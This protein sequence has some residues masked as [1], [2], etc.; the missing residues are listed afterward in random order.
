LEWEPAI[1]TERRKMRFLVIVEGVPGVPL[2]PPEQSLALTKAQ[3]EWAKGTKDSG[4]ADVVYALADHDGGLTGGFGIANVQSLEE[5][6][7][8]L[9]SMPMAGLGTS[10]VYP[11]VDLNSALKIVD[12]KLEALPK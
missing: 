2:L 3:W 7:E 5:L 11:L 4:K 1:L 10:K 9:A 6:A 8:L 12:A